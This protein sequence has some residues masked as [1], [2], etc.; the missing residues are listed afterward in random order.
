MILA[1]IDRAAALVPVFGARL[2][3]DGRRDVFEREIVQAD[4]LVAEPPVVVRI[5]K[6][7]VDLDDTGEIGNGVG[8]AAD[9]GER[10]AAIAVRIDQLGV[11][12]DRRVEIVERQ[13]KKILLPVRAAACVVGA[14]ELRRRLLPAFD[15]RRA[16]RQA[17]VGV[18]PAAFFPVSSAPP[19][20]RETRRRAPQNAQDARREPGAWPSVSGRCVRIGQVAACPSRSA[21]SSSVG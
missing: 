6:I 2:D 7:R 14:G 4:Q 1:E 18:V 20:L 3:L 12:F 10:D 15:E 21:T 13:R 11:G 17:L 16:R 19:V 8:E 5:G 9:D